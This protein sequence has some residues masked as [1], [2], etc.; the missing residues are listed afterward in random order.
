MDQP[1]LCS[2]LYTTS[3]KRIYYS[4]EPIIE[5]IPFPNI[6]WLNTRKK[7]YFWG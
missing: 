7:P 2:M 3:L 4:T 1:F 6:V 5:E